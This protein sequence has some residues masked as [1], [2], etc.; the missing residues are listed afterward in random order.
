DPHAV[1]SLSA[2]NIGWPQSSIG[3]GITVAMQYV[4]PHAPQL[5]AIVLDLDAS[6]FDV[7]YRTHLPRLTGLYDSKG[8]E[9]DS[10]NG[11]Y[12]GGLP[13]AVVEKAA[14]FDEASWERLDA[15]GVRRDSLIGSG[16]G[17]PIIEGT[18]YAIGDSVVQSN[19]AFL[20]KMVDTA[21]ARNVHVLVVNYPQN[22]QYRSTAMAGRAGPSHATFLQFAEIL[23]EMEL[24]TPHFHFYDANNLGDHD[25]S[26]DEAYD[27]N[28]L[29]A[30][31]AAKLAG[32]IDSLLQAILK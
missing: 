9:L 16:W 6:Y 2:L 5:E 24:K 26:D 7:D 14:A 18:D 27:T 13:Q 32:R 25:Y 21:A 3:V 8:Y 19:L 1:Q 11:F 22:P 23:H 31:G 15:S 20:E 29:N 17:E 12:R 30:R 4:L 10:S 28:H